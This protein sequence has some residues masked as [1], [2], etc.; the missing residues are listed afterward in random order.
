MRFDK[1]TKSGEDAEK[2]YVG[3]GLVPVRI[4]DGQP[5]GLSL[6]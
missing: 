6:H 5:Q 3:T 2:S 4:L 1:Y